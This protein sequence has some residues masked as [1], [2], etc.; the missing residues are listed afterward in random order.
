M[1]AYSIG[2]GGSLAACSCSCQLYARTTSPLLP[3]SCGMWP[4]AAAH[5]PAA[6]LWPLARRRAARP[7]PAAPLRAPACASWLGRL[8]L[9]C[10]HV[11]PPGLVAGSDSG[12][13]LVVVCVVRVA[14]VR[15]APLWPVGLGAGVSSAACARGA[16]CAS[17]VRA[18]A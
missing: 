12:W 14:V 6:R 17:A 10:W 18:L 11:L 16:R 13:R 4:L 2:I 1:P 7:G 8:A 15:R 5:E 9:C 3:G